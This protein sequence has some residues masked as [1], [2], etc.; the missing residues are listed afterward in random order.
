MSG[1]S[2]RKEGERGDMQMQRETEKDTEIER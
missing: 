2:N 1:Y